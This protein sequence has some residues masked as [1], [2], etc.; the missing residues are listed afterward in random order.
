MVGAADATKNNAHA[1]A[2]NRTLVSWVA[3]YVD[4]RK[5]D[6]QTHIYAHTRKRR[7]QRDYCRLWREAGRYRILSFGYPERVCRL[8]CRPHY[9]HHNHHHHH[10]HHHHNQQQHHEAATGT[11]VRLR[12]NTREETI[13]QVPRRP[14]PVLWR[15]RR[16]WRQRVRE[17]GG[18]KRRNSD[19]PR[20]QHKYT[21]DE[22]NS[23]ST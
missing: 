5:E 22:T 18:E 15:T 16:A 14:T 19:Q 10:H 11:G 17:G 3:G 2:S 8:G 7:R 1:R 21:P 13:N 12:R 20:I 23:N 6:T 4:A 9:H